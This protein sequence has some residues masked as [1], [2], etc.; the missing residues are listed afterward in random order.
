MSKETAIIYVRVST[1][2]QKEGESIPTQKAECTKYRKDK[3]FDLSHPIF[4]E[5]RSGFLPGKR[6]AYYEMLEYIEKSRPQHLI[7][8]LHDRLSR[9]PGQ[10]EDLVRLCIEIDHNLILHD[11]YRRRSFGILDDEAYEELAEMRK[12]II[13]SGVESAKMRYR[14]GKSIKRL[15][16]KGIY[17]GYAPVGYRN[18]VGTGRIVVDEERAPLVIRTFNLFATGDFSLDDVFERM[19][20]EG[21]TVR[22][23][24]KERQEIMPCRPISRAEVWRLL[25][26]P[27]YHGAFKW[28]DQLWDNRGV[29]K[30]NKPSYSLL[31][32]KEL[33]DKVQAIFEKNRGRRMIRSGKPFLY[34]NL[35]ECRYCG[36]TLVGDGNPLGPYT[37]YHCTSGKRSVDPDFY[38]KKFGTEKCLQRQWKEREITEAVS[39]ALGDLDFDQSIFNLLREQI[40]GEV[41]D[42]HAAAGDELAVLRRRRQ[43]LID[44]KGRNLQAKMDGKVAP[45]ELEDFN[46]V[47]DQIRAELEEINGQIEELASQDGSFVEEG[48]ET[49]EIAHDFL[50]LFKNKKLT[51]EGPRT[52]EGLL[53]Q[54]IMLKTIFRNMMVGDPLPHPKYGKPIPAKNYNGI[55]FI[56]N[57]P[58]D[59][60]WETKLIDQI[61]K[62]SKAW[63]AAHGDE[64]RLPDKKWRG[65][66]DSNSRPP[67]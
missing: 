67:A 33:Y 3:S 6:V 34:R 60:L 43:E 4:E 29:E 24:N 52:E 41:A 55:E 50:N 11:I 51:A 44:K 42:R 23:P 20:R 58:F 47:Q 63:E 38:K 39:Q 62:D 30:K 14:V 61:R 27:F 15:L 37:Y 17:P 40:T 10:F 25:K 36:C 64:I 12:A 16:E 53:Q 49:L 13:N 46:M 45:D 19:Q 7:F 2:D 1:R 56:W 18:V 5:A 57:E 26:N 28:G 32:S 21:L 9:D 8:L 31:I 59:W 65:R 54:K 48:L 35:L 22:T 66:R